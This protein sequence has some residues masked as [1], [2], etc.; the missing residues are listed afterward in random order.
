VI[1]ESHTSITLVVHRG[2]ITNSRLVEPEL[3]H[4][5]LDLY[6]YLVRLYKNNKTVISFTKITKLNYQLGAIYNNARS[7]I[8]LK[9]LLNENTCTL[10]TGV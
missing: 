9:R 2:Y 5:T 4:F 8:L 3:I 7:Y 10:C 1:H 6:Q